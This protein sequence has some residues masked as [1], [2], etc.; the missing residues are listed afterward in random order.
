MAEEQLSAAGDQVEILL[1]VDLD[2]LGQQRVH[3]LTRHD[4]AVVPCPRR[5]SLRSRL[6][7]EEP[8]PAAEVAMDLPRLSG[9]PAGP[10]TFGTEQR[11]PK[12]A[13]LLHAVDAGRQ[14]FA[15]PDDPHPPKAPRRLVAIGSVVPAGIGA[16]THPPNQLGGSTARARLD[17][18]GPTPTAARD[19]IL[20]ESVR[21]LLAVVALRT[22]N[23][24]IQRRLDDSRD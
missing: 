2:C 21:P 3:N 15:K 10:V 22:R 7:D 11:H 8:C 12:E 23:Y 4:V 6:L 20:E 9:Q 24:L 5:G 17:C 14:P 1:V 19:G 16:P 13:P 18:P